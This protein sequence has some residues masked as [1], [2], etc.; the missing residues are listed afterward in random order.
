MSC[1]VKTVYSR[2]VPAAFRI[3]SGFWSTFAGWAVAVHLS[4]L[5]GGTVEDLITLVV[6]GMIPCGL[7]GVIYLTSARRSGSGGIP[8]VDSADGWTILLAVLTALAAASWFVPTEDDAL[9]GSLATSVTDF[10]EAPLASFDWVHG[11]RS[12][13]VPLSGYGTMSLE[14]LAGTLAWFTNTEALLWAHQVFPFLFGFAA[15]LGWC[16]LLRVLAPERWWVAY[17]LTLAFWVL[18]PQTMYSWFGMLHVGK[19]LLH[20]ALWPFLS[21]AA[22]RF[23]R[24]PSRSGWCLLLVSQVSAA[25]LNPTGLWFGPV[26]LGAA[27]LAAPGFSAAGRWRRMLPTAGLALLASAYPLGFGAGLFVERYTGGHQ[28]TAEVSPSNESSKE[29]SAR[30]RAVSGLY[31]VGRDGRWFD[32]ARGR[33][34]FAQNGWA[35]RLPLRSAPLFLGSLLLVLAFG[36]REQRYFLAVNA[37]VVILLFNPVAAAVLSVIAIPGPTHWRVLW[38]FP[39]AMVVGLALS[40]P[41]ATWFRQVSVRSRAAWMGVVLAACAALYF[42]GALLPLHSAA[43][44]APFAIRQPDRSWYAKRIGDLVPAGSTILVSHWISPWVVTYRDHPQPLIVRRH[45]D[46]IYRYYHSTADRLR[47]EALQAAVGTG[48]AGQCVLPL[49]R[50]WNG[51]HRYDVRALAVDASCEKLSEFSAMLEGIGFQR[52][53]LEPPES[54]GPARYELWWRSPDPEEVGEEER[55]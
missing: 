9:Y 23:M 16:V 24:A 48:P 13:G 7:L 53:R 17:L 55:T 14:L 12:A 15:G 19:A 45:Y 21:V 38:L 26:A 22:L 47:R 49:R 42:H 50:L 8:P 52:D 35:W 3:L 28:A 5:T 41:L 2:V 11:L 54:A 27:V 30:P 43:V 40:L 39:G 32:L 51:I 31:T 25:G 18:V 29:L 1:A 37:A 33:W 36:S 44:F 46:Y 10:P 34:I 4:V 20:L 6:V